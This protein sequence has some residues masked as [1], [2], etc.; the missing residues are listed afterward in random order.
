MEFV[1]GQAFVPQFSGGGHDR[2]AERQTAAE[3]AMYAQQVQHGGGYS[4]PPAEGYTEGYRGQ[5]G[6]AE[7]VPGQAFVPAEGYRGLQRATEGRVPGRWSGAV[8]SGWWVG[9]RG[10]GRLVRARLHPP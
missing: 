9:S 1:P 10:H 3:R 2:D 6:V 5:A 7:F 4:G 8:R